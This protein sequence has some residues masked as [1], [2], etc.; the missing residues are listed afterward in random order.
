MSEIKY[1]LDV[2]DNQRDQELLYQL[3]MP[4]N[5]NIKTDY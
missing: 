4:F 5:K 3:K 1:G 2:L